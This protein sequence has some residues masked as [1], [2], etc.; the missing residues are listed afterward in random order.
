MRRAALALLLTL[1]VPLL[2]FGQHH[3]SEG[4][5]A[6]PTASSSSGGY[7]GSSEAYHSSS[8]SSSSSG[9]SS[10]SSSSGGSH[11][12]SGSSGGSSSGTPSGSSGGSRSSSGG[13]SPSS[14]HSGTGSSG[15]H[16]V[17][18]NNASRSNMRTG[19]SDVSRANVGDTGS[20]SRTGSPLALGNPNDSRAQQV[21]QFR[22]EHGAGTTLNQALHAGQMNAEL[23]K[24]GLEPTKKAYEQKVAAL[25]AAEKQSQGKK[26][27]WF[28]KVF[29][30]KQEK[31][32]SLQA[33]ATK[34][35]V[36]ENCKP[37]PKPCQ[38]K[39]CRPVPPPCQKTKNC[40]PP[41]GTCLTVDGSPGAGCMPWGYIERCDDRQGAC[42]AHSQALGAGRNARFAS[43]DRRAECMFERGADHGV[44]FRDG[45]LSAGAPRHRSIAQAIPVVPDGTEPIT[46]FSGFTDWA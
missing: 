27:N 7:S 22:L 41:P 4:G 42:Y 18:G 25:Q 8:S 16:S 24:L 20:E 37:A 13:G 10:S 46:E 31:K 43:F 38:G 34:P 36:G 26:P 35:C 33:A 14:F 45:E 40:L 23:L 5:S 29:L 28:S 17:A 44:L 9:G 21:P 12:S 6:P 30:G 39:S 11:S 1:C 19:N 2:L 32:S 15:S 3:A